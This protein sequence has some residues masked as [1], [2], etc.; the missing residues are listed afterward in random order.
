M[1]KFLLIKH[2]NPNLDKILDWAKEIKRLKVRM[3]ADTAEDVKQ[4]LLF[5]AEGIGL[6]RTEHM[7]F[8]Q[9]KIWT[10]RETLMSEKTERAKS[11]DNLYQ[12]QVA[13]FYDIFKELNGKLAN[14]RLL[15]PP[16]HE[17]L[18]K[19]PEDMKECQKF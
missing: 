19:T 4:G 3:N 13:N 6:C 18:P 17:F 9:D 10:I 16:V 1:E 12:L 2:Q 8:K 15:D 14:I 7:F 5:G 11:L